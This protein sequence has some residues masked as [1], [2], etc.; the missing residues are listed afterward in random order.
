M[1]AHSGIF[2]WKIPWTAEP[3]SLQS[4]RLQRVRH[5]WVT[6]NTH[7]HTCTQ[8]HAHTLTHVHMHTHSHSH[9]YTHSHT[10]AHAHTRTHTHTRTHASEP[11]P[12]PPFPESQ[13]KAPGWKPCLHMFCLLSANVCFRH[14]KYKQE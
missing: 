4:M 10:R 11:E 13:V 1:A 5:D 7:T 8:T 3:G 6:E 12:L 14:R 9:T 2:A